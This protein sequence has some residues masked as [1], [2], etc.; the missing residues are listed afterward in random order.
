MRTK[1]DTWKLIDQKAKYYFFLV[2][3]V[4]STAM[5]LAATG[6]KAAGLA[7]KNLTWWMLIGLWVLIILHGL[8]LRW[9]NARH[10]DKSWTKWGMMFSLTVMIFLMRLSTESAPETHALGYFFIAAAVFFFDIR[11]IWY[12]FVASI[13]V[14]VTMWNAFPGEMEA[15]L[16]VPRDIAIRYFCYLWTSLAAVYIV[17]AVNTLFAIASQREEEATSMTMQLQTILGRVQN[18]SADLF[19]NTADLQRTSD[20]NADSIRVIHNQAISLQGISRNQSEHMQKNVRVL[21]EIGMGSH[22]VGDNATEISSK[23][24]EF[25]SVVETGTQAIL[26]QEESL[27]ITEKTNRDI[28]LAVKEL[29]SN[30]NQ[31]ESIVGTILGIAEQTNLLALNAAIEAARAGEQG[32]G[33]AVVAGEVRNLADETKAA[34]ATIDQLVKANKLSTDN[35]V[36]KVNESAAAL[37][38]QREAMNS[39]HA[40]FDN[41]Q[42][43]SN[44]ISNAVQEIT[45]C[46]EELIA[47]SDESTTLVGRVAEL[48]RTASGCTDDILAE[49]ARHRGLVTKLEEEITQ[50]GEL[51]KSLQAEANQT[52]S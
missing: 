12:A 15:F 4:V 18:L 11:L 13:V 47:S 17:K 6:T 36:V 10:S 26:S 23:T 33:F 42:T 5:V 20:E 34:V 3:T 45:A 38:G 32:R 24:S 28:M 9:L 50:F 46:V 1:S 16:K 41:I 30:S 8:W 44:T 21:D 48:S 49:I 25:M 35:T 29:E 51:A 7:S 27:R 37:T 14:D 22:H 19:K 43:V 39:T 52:M 2:V 31:I 40:A